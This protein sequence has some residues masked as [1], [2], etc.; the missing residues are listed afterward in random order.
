MDGLDSFRS[1]AMTWFENDW[2]LRLGRDAPPSEVEFKRFFALFDPWLPIE[3]RRLIGDG[4]RKGIF[5]TT[6]CKSHA[7]RWTDM[8]TWAIDI[9]GG[10]REDD[11]QYVLNSPRLEPAQPTKELFVQMAECVRIWP[12]VEEFDLLPRFWEKAFMDLT[13]QRRGRRE[14]DVYLEFKTSRRGSGGAEPWL[15]CM[16]DRVVGRPIPRLS[17]RKMAGQFAKGVEADCIKKAASIVDYGPKIFSMIAGDGADWFR[18]TFLVK[19]LDQESR[20]FNLERV[21]DDPWGPIRGLYTGTAH[22]GAV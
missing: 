4:F 2:R 10:S 8:K 1:E 5:I 13:L 17:T 18:R 9:V 6:R 3:M 22:E 19:N 11:P 12:I 14:L 16:Q 15:R 7:R 21:D 20:T